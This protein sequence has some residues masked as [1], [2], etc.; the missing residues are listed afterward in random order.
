MIQETL[1][2][3]TSF[4]T[5]R[6]DHD[7]SKCEVCCLKIIIC[8]ICHKQ[9]NNPEKICD[10]CMFKKVKYNT[11]QCL[12]CHQFKSITDVY[13]QKCYKGEEHEY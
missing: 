2:G 6:P 8:G 12:I 9:T 10:W 4:C 11:D 1:E 13:K 3:T 7:C 5:H